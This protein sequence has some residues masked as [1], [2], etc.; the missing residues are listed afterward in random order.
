MA[1]FGRRQQSKTKRKRSAGAGASR[2][3]GEFGHPLTKFERFCV[4]FSV[5][6]LSSTIHSIVVLDHPDLTRLYSLVSHVLLLEAMENSSPFL[7]CTLHMSEDDG[8]PTTASWVAQSLHPTF[9]LR[10][11]VLAQFGH[12]YISHVCRFTSRRRSL[13]IVIPAI[14][15]HQ[16]RRRDQPLRDSSSRQPR[17]NS[18]H[19]SLP[20]SARRFLVFKS[21]SPFGR[22]TSAQLL[23]SKSFC[24]FQRSGHTT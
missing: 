4:L 14:Y 11:H 23:A 15:D 8:T 20:Q 10:S 12:V 1:F 17:V 16:Q 18:T 6:T 19:T 2:R 7:R 9:G 24:N 22:P 5:F 3:H 21:F 13:C